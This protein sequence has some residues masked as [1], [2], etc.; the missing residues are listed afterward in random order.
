MGIPIRRGRVF[1][2]A[3]GPGPAH[4]AVISQSLAEAQW[5][6]RD[7]LGRYIQF[8]NMDG[9]LTGLRVVGVVGDVRELS[10]EALPGRVIYVA[11]RQRPRTTSASPSSCAGPACAPWRSRCA[12]SCATSRRRR[13]TSCR[14]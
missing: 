6:G 4:V 5:P 12:G 2:A 11:A 13:R 9:D 3:D 14:R 10:P 1:E 8:G 7:P